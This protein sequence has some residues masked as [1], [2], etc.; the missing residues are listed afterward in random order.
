MPVPGTRVHSDEKRV[1]KHYSFYRK[2]LEQKD[3]ILQNVF[4]LSCFLR[5][6]S[7]SYDRIIF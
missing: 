1:K 2:Y 7:I 3:A 4:I 6:D 5:N